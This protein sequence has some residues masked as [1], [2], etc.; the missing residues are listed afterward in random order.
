MNLLNIVN[1]LKAEL[2]AGDEMADQL[3]ARVDAHIRDLEVLKAWIRD[4]AKAR[5]MT[6]GGMLGAEASLPVPAPV[7]P[8]EQ[9]D[10]AA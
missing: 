9:Q 1:E 5:S 7:P 2:A 4:A 8:A 6:I 3:V 10:E